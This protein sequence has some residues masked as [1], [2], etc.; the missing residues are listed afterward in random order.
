MGVAGI[1]EVDNEVVSELLEVE[2]FYTAQVNNRMQ[3]IE[4]HIR[5]FPEIIDEVKKDFAELDSMNRD[6]K[7][8]LNENIRNKEVVEAM[9]RNYKI[10]LEILEDMY[11]QIRLQEDTTNSNNKNNENNGYDI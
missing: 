3:E 11:E 10:K 6:L 5:H 1:E 8:D 7:S 2:A 9:I 4:K